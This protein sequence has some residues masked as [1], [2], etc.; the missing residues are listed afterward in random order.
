MDIDAFKFAAPEA[1]AIAQI[2]AILLLAVAFSSDMRGVLGVDEM[3]D[4]DGKRWRA[5][6]KPVGRGFAQYRLVSLLASLLVIMVDGW[7]VLS[8]PY[9]GWLALV[10][11]CGNSVVLGALVGVMAILIIRH[12]IDRDD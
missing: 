10:L 11:V 9:T 12:M 1:G 6:T 7:V 8:G 2:L 3:V 4:S 5:A